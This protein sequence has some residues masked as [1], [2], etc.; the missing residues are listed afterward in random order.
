[1]LTLANRKLSGL[2]LLY[3][4]AAACA[5][6]GCGSN[7]TTAQSPRWGGLSAEGPAI[8]GTDLGKRTFVLSNGTSV[9]GEVYDS[10]G[11]GVAD[12][13]DLDGDGI[14][15][16]EDINGDGLITIWA[17][18]MGGDDTTTADSLRKVFPQT[19]DTVENLLEK[20]APLPGETAAGPVVG[21]AGGVNLVGGAVPTGM[22]IPGVLAARQQAGIGSCG[23]FAAAGAVTLLRYA[24][25]QVANPAIDPNT[26]WPSPLYVYQYNAKFEMGVCS[27]TNIQD[28]LSRFTLFG[29]PSEAELS[30]PPLDPWPSGKNAAYCTAPMIDPSEQSPNRNAFRINGYV[31]IT[32]SG[33]AFRNSV[34]RQ[35]D[36][37]RPV[38]F[39]TTLP[40]G[41]Q[42]FRAT[43]A[44][45][46][47]NMP[48]AATDVTKPFKGGGMC[49][50]SGHCGGH[51][52]V[53][54]GYDDAKNAYRVL[55]SW[56]GDWGDN[57]YLWWDYDSLEA[58]SPYGSA[59][60]ALPTDAAPL[61]PPDAMGLTVTAVMMAPPV[62]AK[63]PLC[64]NQTGWGLLLRVRFSEPVTV[65]QVSLSLNGGPGSPNAAST[66]M[67]EGDVPALIGES[68]N[69]AAF[70][71]MSVVGQSGTVTINA[72]L[73][74]GATVTHTIGP[75]TVPAPTQ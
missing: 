33:A 22:P 68:V 11:D 46:T 39:G 14:S 45:A 41:F 53:F 6:V 20:M 30:Y 17:D 3:L 24:R 27:G 44:D 4:L 51:A 26:L 40:I 21:A 15:D 62:F 29:S 34:K 37:G 10:N 12:E 54:T 65:T 43:T 1:M 36:M 49:T 9:T 61:L 32:G 57:G 70:D 31:D 23:A 38:V 69:N 47:D 25:E 18:L 66:G 2:S 7:K 19:S 5:V 8:S 71:P 48:G 67:F 72:T 73:R 74:N 35:L 13:V 52:M 63:V 75:I 56:G 60:I 58:L 64:C 28:N 16:G 55:N 50:T 59:P 42:E